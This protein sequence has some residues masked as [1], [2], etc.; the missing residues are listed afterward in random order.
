[1]LGSIKLNF[2]LIKNMGIR[3]VT[4]RL[5]HE[6]EKKLGLLKIKHPID[7]LVQINY[8]LKNWRESSPTCVIENKFILNKEG[9]ES[10][11]IKKDKILSGNIQFFN[12][13]WKNIGLN[14]D[15]ITNPETGYKY[16]LNHW[17]IINDFNNESGDIKFVWEKSR[18]SYLITIMRA[19]FHLKEDYSEFVFDEIENWIDSNPT[20]Q[21]PNWKCSQEISLRIFNLYFLLDYYKNSPNLTESRWI[22]IQNLIYWSLDHVYKHINFSRIAVRNNHAI[23]ETL[24]L[25]ISELLFPFIQKTKKWSKKGRKWLEQEID[26]QIYEDG[27]YLQFS[28]NYHRV[29]I[30]LLTLG[31]SLTEKH[32]KPLSEKTYLKA[33]KSLGFLMNCMDANSGF[34]PLYGSNDGALF[35]PF[36]ETNYRDFRPQL[37]TLHYI[38]TG[39]RISDLESIN[40]DCFWY[41][42]QKP[43]RKFTPILPSYGILSYS[44]GGFYLIKEKDYLTFIRCGNHKD[45]PAQAD[46]LHIDLWYNGENILGDS[47]SY[48][49]N[50]SKENLGFF[51]GTKGHNTVTIEDKSQMLKG[52]RFIWYYWTQKIYQKNHETE[53]E[54]I[55]EGEISAF[56]YINKKITHKRKIQK[57]KNE[58]IWIVSDEITN[59]NHLLKKQLWH[60]EISKI[61]FHAT[62]NKN[63]IIP[64]KSKSYISSYYGE[65]LDQ[66]S[67]S[68]Q[69]NNSITTNI[70]IKK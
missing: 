8:S 57:I 56:K 21:G 2:E 41:A 20:N 27:T 31:I 30:Q 58:P 9:K 5:A 53:T 48:K 66:D 47:G 65:K 3:Y 34:L 15:W 69:F 52:S 50:T 11:Q 33:Y 28:M 39:E 62:E 25:T 6:F 64:S 24:F 55:F 44:E 18:F 67:I 32:N 14:Y 68:F 63:E 61:D 19:D 45:R 42:I 37:N 13:N 1:M 38:L 36:S 16:N 43:K 12:N 7:K 60:G 35:F 4:Y 51:M 10:L 23:T 17:S 46:N 29:V 49:Y 22:K 70:I 40:E 26:Y 59:C 54:Y